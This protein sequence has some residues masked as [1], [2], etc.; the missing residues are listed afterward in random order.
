[1]AMICV[2]GTR[3]C[4]GSMACQ[5]DLEPISCEV[6][7]AGVEHLFK[8]AHG[9]IVGCNHCITEFDPYEL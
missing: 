5:K 2:K 1:M 9:D 3:E 4:I 6:C 7:G 8:D